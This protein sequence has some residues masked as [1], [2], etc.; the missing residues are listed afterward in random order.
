MVNERWST[1][2]FIP[3][4]TGAVSGK[5]LIDCGLGAKPRAIDV[6]DG[7]GKPGAL[8]RAFVTHI[9]K[10]EDDVHLVLIPNEDGKAWH[11]DVIHNE[12]L[13]QL[14]RITLR[15]LYKKLQLIRDND[16]TVN[17]EGL[18]DAIQEVVSKAQLEHIKR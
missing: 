15:A 9:L 7:S 12:P 1:A 5:T 13:P 18:D 8:F 2:K 6:P 16:L 10:T 14:N 11:I 17:Q 3:E 4:L